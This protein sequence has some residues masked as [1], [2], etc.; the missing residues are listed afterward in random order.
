MTH[1]CGNTHDD[2]RGF[3]LPEEETRECKLQVG[4]DEFPAERSQSNAEVVLA[5][6]GVQGH[7]HLRRRHL[8]TLA[9]RGHLQ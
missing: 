3:A 1:T 4:G 9:G 6:A 7:V 5:D 2:S 8:P